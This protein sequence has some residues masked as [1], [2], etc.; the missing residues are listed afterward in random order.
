[1]VTKNNFDAITEMW[2]KSVSGLNYTT[3]TTM[4]MIHECN[5]QRFTNVILFEI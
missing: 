2:N 1:M 4:A 5:E 3:L